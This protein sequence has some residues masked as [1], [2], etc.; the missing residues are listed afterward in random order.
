VVK[1]GDTLRL[2]YNPGIDSTNTLAIK[3]TNGP[4]VTVLKQYF[5][6]C[7]RPI[8]DKFIIP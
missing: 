7:A 6:T 4:A 3:L 5:N 8:K 2:Y 1:P